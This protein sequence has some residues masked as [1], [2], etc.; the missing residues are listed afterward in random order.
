MKGV[1]RLFVGGGQDYYGDTSKRDQEV[2][3]KIPKELS[4]M[5]IKDASKNLEIVTGG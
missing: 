1:V 4:K 3:S 2:V 5:L